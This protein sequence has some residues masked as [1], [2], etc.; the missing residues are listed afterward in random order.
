MTT[1]GK[2]GTQ[3]FGELPS[4]KKLPA[5]WR[6]LLVPTSLLDYGISKFKKQLGKKEH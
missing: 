3:P 6:K 5:Y 4:A 2:E 1:D